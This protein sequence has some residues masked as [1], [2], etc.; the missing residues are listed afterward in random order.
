M[1][2]VEKNRWLEPSAPIPVDGGERVAPVHEIRIRDLRARFGDA[3]IY[4]AECAC[5]WAGEPR[6]GRLAD[7]TARR[8]GLAHVE[9]ELPPYGHRARARSENPRH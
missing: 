8:E 7:R 4:R 6:T 1:N 9:G 3:E 5:G 2:R